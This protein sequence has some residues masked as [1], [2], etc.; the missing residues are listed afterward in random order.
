MSQHRAG[1]EAV[2]RVG[3]ANC[4]NIAETVERDLFFDGVYKLAG[5]LVA[6]EGPANFARTDVGDNLLIRVDEIWLLVSEVKGTLE[7][8]SCCAA[9]SEEGRNELLSPKGEFGNHYWEVG[10]VWP[11]EYAGGMREGQTICSSGAAAGD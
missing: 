4:Q 10:I 6:G 2:L 11:I 9:L 1:F 8:H 5:D 7:S 3:R